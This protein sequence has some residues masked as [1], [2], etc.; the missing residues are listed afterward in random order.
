MDG[1]LTEATPEFVCPLGQPPSFIN[2]WSFPQSGGRTHKG[3]N[4]LTAH[5]RSQYA[6]VEETVSNLTGSLG[7]HVPDTGPQLPI[8]LIGG[9]CVWPYGARFTRLILSR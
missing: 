9:F 8:E 1:L 7:G 3:T 2:D 6:V 5:G 4:M